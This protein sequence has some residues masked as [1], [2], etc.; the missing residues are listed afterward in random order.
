MI[1]ANEKNI[2]L[3]GESRV[4]SYATVHPS[5]D[6]RWRHPLLDP[7]ISVNITEFLSPY[8][9]ITPHLR[10][11]S[12]R[13]KSFRGRGGERRGGS[14]ESGRGGGGG[15]RKRERE[16]EFLGCILK[17][18]E[19]SGN[20]REAK[21]AGGTDERGPSSGFIFPFVCPLLYQPISF[22]TFDLFI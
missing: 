19:L 12:R 21:S 6:G 5:G 4:A 11:S 22:Y 16:I 9:R 17:S 14:D 18:V 1:A 15:E 10:S 7:R 13:P 2:Q 8:Y 3:R 20:C